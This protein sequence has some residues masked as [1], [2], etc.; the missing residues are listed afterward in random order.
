MSRVLIVDDE[1]SIRLTLSEFLKKAGYQTDTAKNVE[2][3]LELFEQNSY[4][5]IITDIVMPKISG[6]DFLEMIRAKS[7]S[8]QVIIVT[9]D[10]SVET[11]MRAVKNGANDY[12][13]K[14]LKKNTLLQTVKRAS[15][16]KALH[17]E[18]ELLEKQNLLYRQSLEETVVKR[19]KELE[20]TMIGVI[21]LMFTIVKLKDPYTDLHQ[22]RVGNLAA[23]IGEKMN[24]DPNKT[25]LLRVIGYMHDIGKIAVPIEILS[26]PGNLSDLEMEMIRNHSL[27]GYEMIRNAHIP[28]VIAEA[29]LQ[30]HER[31]DGSGYPKGLKAD[32]ICPEAKILMLA[33]VIA[34]ISSH[35]PYRPALGIQ[36]ALDEIRS[37][38][39]KLYDEDIV[40]V[41]EALLLSDN[42]IFDET[43]HD[44]LV[45]LT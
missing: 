2:T 44:I 45:S 43:Q 10:P 9:G 32:S 8:I 12:M 4:D 38:S 40:H 22:T 24:L 14:P 17:D 18:K 28:S 26:K 23:A 7:S 42:Y 16:V 6:M 21:K 29:V 37:N 31:C 39:G 34:A 27:Y 20:L 33:D 13:T 25:E 35:R 1:K 3:A 11:A 5:V 36:A 41:C 19:T 30:H 15:E